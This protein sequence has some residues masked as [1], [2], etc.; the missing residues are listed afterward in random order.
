[1]SQKRTGVYPSRYVSKTGWIECLPHR[2]THWAA[3]RQGKLIGRYQCHR[4]ASQTLEM[5]LK[6]RGAPVRKYSLGRQMGPPE[7]KSR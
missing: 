2:A 1:M 5:E 3:Y 6:R 4:Q 7:W